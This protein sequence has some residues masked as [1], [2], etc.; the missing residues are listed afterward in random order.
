ME[1]LSDSAKTNASRPRAGAAKRRVWWLVAGY[2]ALIFVAS[3]IPGSSVPAAAGSDKLHHAIEYGGLGV[4]LAYALLATTRWSLT[5]IVV[6]AIALGG[7]YGVS[8]ELHQLFTPRR[9]ASAADVV[10]DVAGTAIGALC[11]ACVAL[12][13]RRS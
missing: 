7:I 13:R 10:A 9:D 6:V 3:S 1:D 2:C 12:V 4:L 8:D 11:V 5:V